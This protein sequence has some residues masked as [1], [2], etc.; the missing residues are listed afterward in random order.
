MSYSK[1]IVHYSKTSNMCGFSPRMRLTTVN[2]LTFSVLKKK[3][4]FFYKK[5]AKYTYRR[6]V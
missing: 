6:Y 5:W 2:V 4:K 1:D 3:N